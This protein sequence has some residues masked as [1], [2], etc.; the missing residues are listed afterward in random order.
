MIST[1]IKHTDK[2][3]SSFCW[4]YYMFHPFQT[5]VLLAIGV[6]KLCDS[7]LCISLTLYCDLILHIFG[8]FI[9]VTDLLILTGNSIVKIVAVIMRAAN[10]SKIKRFQVL[11]QY[12]LIVSGQICTRHSK[13][14]PQKQWLGFQTHTICVTVGRKWKFLY[15]LGRRQSWKF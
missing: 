3:L 13:Y 6:L 4:A 1:L 11:R 12:I 10:I 2:V 7:P 14:V 8:R 5:F 15:S 9:F